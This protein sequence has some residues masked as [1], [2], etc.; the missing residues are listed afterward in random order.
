MP[1]RSLQTRHLLFNLYLQT[2][3]LDT[4]PETLDVVGGSSC[5]SPPHP[6][7]SGA[8]KGRWS[9]VVVTIVAWP[10]P[11]PTH[12]H[13]NC[14]NSTS[15]SFTWTCQVQGAGFHRSRPSLR[16]P[17]ASW[18]LLG[19]SSHPGHWSGVRE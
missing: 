16:A 12:P 5:T 13:P 14:V 3:R 8:G 6:P 18:G 7:N 4:V 11:H 9:V 15:L 17:V 19:A 2:V 1:Q 10:L